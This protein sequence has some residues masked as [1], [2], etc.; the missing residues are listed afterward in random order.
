[1]V[2]NND[3]KAKETMAM[4]P[5]QRKAH[6]TVKEIKRKYV[7]TY[8]HFMQYIQLKQRRRRL[9]NNDNRN[10]D[11]GITYIFALDITYKHILLY[12]YVCMYLQFRSNEKNDDDS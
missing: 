6:I 4:L 7:Y 5:K 12:M 2:C 3:E 1:M 11:D 10:S 9:Q 8:I